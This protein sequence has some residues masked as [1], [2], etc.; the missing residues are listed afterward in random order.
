MGHREL[1]QT[2]RHLPG[3]YTDR[4]GPRTLQ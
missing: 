3:R 4:L 2:M 1:A